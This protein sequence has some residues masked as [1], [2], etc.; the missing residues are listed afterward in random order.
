V[1]QAGYLRNLDVIRAAS[2]AA[3][4]PFWNF[5]NAMPFNGRPDVTEA[6]LRWL[7]FSSLA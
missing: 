5:F 1:S 6:Q 3:N 7:V 2:L 4:I